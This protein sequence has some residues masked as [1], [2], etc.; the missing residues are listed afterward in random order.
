MSVRSQPCRPCSRSVCQ[1][2]GRRSAFLILDGFGIKRRWHEQRC[3]QAKESLSAQLMSVRRDQALT[4]REGGPVDDASSSTCSTS[5]SFASSIGGWA[6]SSSSSTSSFNRDAVEM[7]PCASATSACEARESDASGSYARQLRRLIGCSRRKRSI[8]SAAERHGSSNQQSPPCAVPRRAPPLMPAEAASLVQSFHVAR[9]LRSVNADSLD[10]TPPLAWLQRLAKKTEVAR[11]SLEMPPQGEG[12]QGPLASSQGA[13]KMEVWYRWSSSTVISTRT[14]LSVPGK[15]CEVLSIFRE[16]DLVHNW[17]PFVTGGACT[18]SE[19][20]PALV[21]TLHAKIPLLPRSVS[22]MIHRVFI[23]DFEG[24]SKGVFTVEWTP[25]PEEVTE[26]SYCGIAVPPAPARSSAVQVQLASSLVQPVPGQENRCII[27]M[28]GENDF[29]VNRRLIPDVVLR[30]FLTLNS[31]VL[32][33]K[34]C[35]CLQDMESFGYT[36]RLQRDPQGFYAL[37]ESRAEEHC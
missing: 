11:P 25:S 37:V 27:T 26:G 23:D 22:T 2:C 31:Q 10:E 29:K 1:H 35:A 4:L 28:A 6:A 32:A 17:L 12:W 9:A 3:L 20:L 18:W 36:D 15:L 21:T 19:D 8:L 14:C 30:K 33:S 13:W 16:A 34:I 7:G 24:P 5:T